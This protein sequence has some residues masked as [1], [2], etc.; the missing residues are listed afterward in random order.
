V[1]HDAV[2]IAIGFV[3]G[4]IGSREYHLVRNPLDFREIAIQLRKD[5]EENVRVSKTF[6]DPS[7]GA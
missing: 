1:W 7:N 6:H 3:A 4:W 2:F 5:F